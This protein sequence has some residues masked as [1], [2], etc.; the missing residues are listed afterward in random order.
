MYKSILVLILSLI[1]Q[2][3]VRSQVIKEVYPPE[4][5]KSIIVKSESKQIEFPVIHLNNQNI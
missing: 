4:F 1:C 5:V 3:S 2:I